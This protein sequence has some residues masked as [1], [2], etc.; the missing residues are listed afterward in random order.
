MTETPELRIRTPDQRLRVFVSSSLV[1]LAD[2]RQAVKRAIETLRLTPVM[3]EL[4]ARPYPPRA[5]YRAYL[6]QSHVFLGIY[7]QSYGWVAPDED[8]SGLEDEYRLS[9]EHP[10]LVYV[11]RP[12]DDRHERLGLLL[13]RIETDDQTS[14]R[15]FS[16]VDELEQLVQDDLMVLL[17]ERFEAGESPV[18]STP[19]RPMTAPP[20]PITPIIGREAE[21]AEVRQLLDR[22]TRILTLLGPGGVGKS[23]L[24]LEACQALGSTFPD[25]VAFVPLERVDDPADVMRLVAHSV[26]ATVEG[27]QTPLDV[28]IRRLSGRRVLLLVD[29]FE[30]VLDAGVELTRLLESCP[31]ISVVVTSRRPLQVR[32]EHQLVVEPLALPPVAPALGRVDENTVAASPAVTL[33]VERAQQVRPSF[34]LDGD[35]AEAVAALVARL[36]GLPLAIELASARTKL[37]EPQQILDRLERGVGVSMSAGQDVPERQRTL[38]TTVEWSNDLLTPAQQTLLARLSVFAD[39]ATLDAVE[40]VCAGDPVIDVA[41]DLSTLLDNGLL[42]ADRV[43]S[44]GQPRF[45]LMQIVQDFAADQLDALGETEV[46]TTRFLDWALETATQ[47]DPVLHRDAP[48]RWPELL[49]EARNLRRAAQVMLDREDWRSF[50]RFAWGVFHWIYR[51]DDM[52]SF[53]TWAERALAQ[54]GHPESDADRAAQAR[55][56]A[57][58]CW[59][60]FLVGDIPGALAVQDLVDLDALPESDPACAALLYNSRSL[61]LPLTDGGAQAHDAAERALVLAD[62]SGFAAVSAYTHAFLANLELINGDVASAEQHCQRC[63]AIATDIGTPAMAGQQYAMLALVEIAQGRLEDGRSHLCRALGAAR[64]EASVVDAAVLLGHAAVLAAAEGKTEEAGRLRAASDATMS[65]LGLMQWPMFE[66]ARRAA[67]GGRAVEPA[68][69]GADVL[70]LDPWDELARALAPTPP[71]PAG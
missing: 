2:E 65:R 27:A 17:T 19:S 7:W 52:K 8:V 5:L 53:L 12:A 50:T 30:Q 49:V 11:R 35:N 29:N 41:D 45:V 59:G 60:R 4:G 16:E 55:L 1:E 14:Y 25:G 13:Q 40:A 15:Q 20:V 69:L 61:L 68:E 54:S 62:L 58:V 32:G 28:V 47:G 63:V 57:G 56:V 51:F 44:E 21:V 42:R 38:R 37:L 18:E 34:A 64:V 70:D 3:F 67:L 46:V 39:G 36:D 23:R 71:S 31:G 6:E 26:G 9:D 43:Q 24:A 33:F 66:G 10:R 48:G 22:G